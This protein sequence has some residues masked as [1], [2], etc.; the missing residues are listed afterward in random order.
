MQKTNA[1]YEKLKL[2]LFLPQE[3]DTAHKFWYSLGFDAIYRNKFS[4]IPQSP[5]PPTKILSPDFRPASAS[6]TELHTLLMEV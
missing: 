1:L 5:K 3:H 4:G 6:S 2:F